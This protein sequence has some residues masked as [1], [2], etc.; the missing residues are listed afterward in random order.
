MKQIVRFCLL[1]LF[2]C[3]GFALHA[4]EKNDVLVLLSGERKEVKVTGVND[5]HVKFRYPGEE[6]DNEISKTTLAQVEFGS[7]RVEK[8]GD[9]TPVGATPIKAV[10]SDNHGSAPDRHNKIA[11]LPFE[12]VSNDPGMSPESMSKVV[13]N[14]TSNFVKNDYR[15]LTLQDPM[16]TNA[17]LAKNNID[18]IYRGIPPM[19]LEKF[20][21]W[22]M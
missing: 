7:G 21:E 15:A 17:I 8:F 6:F 5:T 13:Q 4:Q 16:T 3:L 19:N 2:V 1:L 12:F 9:S 14:A 20:S 10:G 11:V 22:N 18:Q